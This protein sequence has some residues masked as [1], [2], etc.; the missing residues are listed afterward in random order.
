MV[1]AATRF[2]NRKHV[3]GKLNRQQ[4]TITDNKTE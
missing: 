4:S 2:L 3:S 1:L